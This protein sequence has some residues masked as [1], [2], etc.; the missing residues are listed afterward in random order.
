MKLSQL[1]A[2]SETI[3]RRFRQTSME[4]VILLI[5]FFICFVLDLSYLTEDDVAPD[6][7]GVEV[8]EAERRFLIDV[9]FTDEQEHHD[10]M[11]GIFW[12]AFGEYFEEILDKTGIPLIIKFLL[13]GKIIKF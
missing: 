3:L 8:Q 11:Q 9:E 6:P 2:I 12:L 7:E 4:I 1:V 13:Y 5:V 10:Y